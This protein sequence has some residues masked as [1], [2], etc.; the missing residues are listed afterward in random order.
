MQRI[1]IPD[2]PV[3]DLERDFQGMRYSKSKGM[4]DIGESMVY[5]EGYAEESEMLVHIP[6]P[7][8][9]KPTKVELTFFFLGENRRETK[10]KFDDYISNGVHSFW[11]TK[12][13]KEL[14]FYVKDPIQVSEDVWCGSK[15]YIRVVYKLSNKFGKTFKKQ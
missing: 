10:D 2:Q 3:Y 5:E 14:R 13:K 6:E 1:D 11:D 7:P 15:P 9:N 8:I 12:R 4:D